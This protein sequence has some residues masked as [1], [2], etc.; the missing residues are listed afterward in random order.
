MGEAA[1]DL[2]SEERDRDQLVVL[3]GATWA[4]FQRLLEIRGDDPC[5][6]FAYLEGMLQIM[7]PSR[8]HE[9]VKSLLGRLVEAWC[10]EVGVEISPYG[11]WTLEKKEAERGV[12]PDECYVLGD[13][14]EPEVPDLAIEVVVSS[15]GIKKLDIYRKLGVREVWFWRKGRIELFALRDEHVNERGFVAFAREA[16]EHDVTADRI[17][18]RELPR[19]PVALEAD[20]ERRRGHAVRAEEADELRMRDERPLVHDAHVLVGR[21]PLA[22]AHLDDGRARRRV[23]VGGRGRRAR[24]RAQRHQRGDQA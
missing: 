11:S 8:K 10:I 21:A 5:P 18:R 1:L 6:R 14:D 19:S 7:N 24:E 9:S 22:R 20:H 15:G 12:E 16:I 2:S 13:A 17:D 3:S 4:D 23:L